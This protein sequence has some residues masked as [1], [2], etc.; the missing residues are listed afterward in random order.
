MHDSVKLPT[1]AIWK[2]SIFCS[3]TADVTT[4]LAVNLSKMKQLVELCP[5][6]VGIHISQVRY[7]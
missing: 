5:L 7:T 3:S 6:N 4:D 2:I 1:A